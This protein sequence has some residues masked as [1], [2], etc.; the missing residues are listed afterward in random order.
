M[1]A[2]RWQR[3]AD[4]LAAAGVDAD[5]ETIRY[6]PAGQVANRHITIR[7]ADGSLVQVRDKY[8]RKNVDVWIGWQ[9]HVDTADGYVGQTWPITKK[10][11]EVVAAVREALVTDEQ[12]MRSMEC[13]V[14]GGDHGVNTLALGECP[15]EIGALR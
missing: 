12:F 5:V 8:W 14:C 9:V 1:S 11:S 7:R 15:D 4:D 3:L 6:S 13:P 2:A 10:R